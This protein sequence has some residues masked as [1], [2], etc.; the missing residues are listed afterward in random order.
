MSWANITAQR[1]RTQGVADFGFF[2]R[3]P[4]NG[5]LSGRF[6]DRYE[7]N[8]AAGFQTLTHINSF[9]IDIG[10]VRYWPSIAHDGSSIDESGILEGQE[11]DELLSISPLGYVLVTTT[12]NL[13]LMQLQLQSGRHSIVH[14]AVRPP[15]GFLGGFGKR[16]ASIIIG[17]SGQDRENV[18]LRI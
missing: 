12:C 5:I 9:L 11:F 18:R 15:S 14:R 3:G 13:V 8:T 7:S 2:D 1:H 17:S 10:D 16:F 6:T 4:A